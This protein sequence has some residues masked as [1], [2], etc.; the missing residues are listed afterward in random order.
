M[1]AIDPPPAAWTI[2]GI[3]I[4]L[5][6]LYWLTGRS[7]LPLPPGPRKLPLVGNLFNLPSTFGWKTFR[8]WN[9]DIIHL[10]LA[11][12]SM[13][14]LSSLEATEALLEKRSS[15]YSDRPAMPMLIDLM[16]WDFNLSANLELINSRQCRRSHRRLFSQAFSVTGSKTFRPKELAATHG[17]L[18]R[19]LHAPDAF[20]A[21]IKQM[22][23][24]VIISVAYGINVLPVKD[25]YISLAEEAVHS[26]GQAV[27]P[28]RFLVDAIPVLKHV[29]DWF[30]GAGFK[31]LAKEWRQVACALTDVP[32]AEVKRQI[33]SGTASHSFTAESLRI[34]GESS[35]T[36]YNEDTIKA[37]AATMYVAGSDTTVAAIST[38]FLAML[39]NPDA[40]KKAQMEIDTVIGQGQLPHFNDEESLPYVSA[41][42]K[43]VLR[44]QPVTPIGVPHFLAVEDEYRGYRIPAGSVVIGNVWAILKDEDMYPD[45]STFKPER[46]LRDGK[47]NP[48]V[49]DPQA[50]FGFGRRICPGRHMAMSSVWIAVVSILAVFDITKAVEDDGQEIEPT[51]EYSSDFVSGPLPFKCSIRP[52]SRDA[53]A[54][55]EVTANEDHHV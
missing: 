48:D 28:G 32:F 24:E 17:L 19:L 35:D 14:V 49:R 53:A 4:V 26:G 22:A 20:R 33:A 43:E 5:S 55:I 16:G 2:A 36:Y 21:H 41:L 12:T 38:F 15:I 13:I 6:I 31:R 45:S 29:P 3:A 50:A 18:R 1:T 8:E 11:G 37:T 7:N 25:P 40:Q 51:Y 27:T 39:A 30:P 10:N 47:L 52:R 46:F 44:W 54:L 23:G 9:S 34:F 42:V